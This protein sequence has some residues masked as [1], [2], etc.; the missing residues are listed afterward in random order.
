[1]GGLQKLSDELRAERH[2]ATTALQEKARLKIEVETL[3]SRMQM[4]MKEAVDSRDSSESSEME[5]RSLR[6]KLKEMESI[7]AQV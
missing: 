2:K 1:M 6:T 5:K 7:I 3:K 4:T